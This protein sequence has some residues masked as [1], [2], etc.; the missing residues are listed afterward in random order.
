MKTEE[1]IKKDVVDELSWDNRVDASDISVQ[2][3][4][5]TVSLAG[6]VPTFSEVNAAQEVANRVVGVST[7]ENN[8]N[9]KFP[10]VFAAPTDTEIQA[11][12]RDRLEDNINV[13]EKN[14]KIMVDGGVVILEG[15]VPSLWEKMEVEREADAARGVVDVRSKLVVVTTEKISDEVLGERVM[16]RI[17][18]NTVVDVDKVDV[19]VKDGKV[20]LSGNVPSWYQWR[21]VFDAAQYTTGVRLVEDD[22]KIFSS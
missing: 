2:V 8:L 13:A 21:S 19:R 10:E 7:I 1:A 16:D 9:V 22:L 17:T 5:N 12:I 3:D 11:S 18:R 14:V 6:T 4:G 15:S 20:K